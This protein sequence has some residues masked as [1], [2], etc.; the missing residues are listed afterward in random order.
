LSGHG[1]WTIVEVGGKWV[2]N[3]G[4]DGSSANSAGIGLPAQLDMSG[5]R[6]TQIFEFIGDPDSGHAVIYEKAQRGMDQ[7]IIGILTHMGL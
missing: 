1:K 3:L 5:W 4:F 2:I 7:F 6:P